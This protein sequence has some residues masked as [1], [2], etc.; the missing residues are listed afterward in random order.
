MND[1]A[2]PQIPDGYWQDAKGAFV[3]IETIK[4]EHQEEDA[5]VKSLV[6]EARN[7]NQQL[8]DF[9]AAAIGDVQA[10]R[11]LIKEK[12]G[13]KKGG[14]KG[15]ITMSSFDGSLQVQVSVAEHITFGPELEAAKSL[16]D[17]C[18]HAWSQGANA[19]LRALVNDAFQTDKQGKI[20][21]QRVLGLRRL[22]MESD[23]AGIW[24]KAMDAISDAVRVT[25][26]K[27][28]LRVYSRNPKTE[29]LE[30]ISLDIASA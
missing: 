2:K 29:N 25:G 22:N 9:K 18:I 11:D 20:N 19:N 27:T 24:A 30:P 6:A 3:P 15:N 26:T 5:L 16:I 4:A 12:Y 7:L 17:E 13:A 10:F 21:T 23:E 8:A 28:Y 14:P 1:H